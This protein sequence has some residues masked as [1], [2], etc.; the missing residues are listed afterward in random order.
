[1]IKRIFLALLVCILLL[2]AACAPK[3]NMETLLSYQSPGTEMTL[4]ITDTE[5]FRAKLRILENEKVLTFT[6]EK[7]EGI[8]YR[9]DQ[10]GNLRMCYDDVEIPLDPSDE[11]KCKR[12]FALFAIPAGEAIWKIRRE[13][14]GGIELFVCR[15]GRI[16]LWIDAAS[17]FP[18]R[19]ESGNVSIDVLSC[20]SEE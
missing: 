13:T 12:W 5:S 14:A 9:L 17:G 20:R 11:L 3:P 4:A 8:T 1:M 6:D 16:T 7:R 15:D 19:I 18:L 2:S 10:G